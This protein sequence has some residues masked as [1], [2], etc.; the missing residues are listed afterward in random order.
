MTAYRKNQ[1]AA[2]MSINLDNY[3]LLYEHEEKFA[4]FGIELPKYS[5]IS[6]L[7]KLKDSLIK[8][9][10]VKNELTDILE[11]ICIND[12]GNLHLSNFQKIKCSPDFKRML[13]DVYDIITKLNADI[14]K[15]RIKVARLCNETF[16][17][18]KGNLKK[19]N[20]SLVELSI[21][22]RFD[23]PEYNSISKT[24]NVVL[25]HI[26]DKDNKDRRNYLSHGEKNILALLLF[27]YSCKEDIVIIDDPASSTDE[28]KRKVILNIIEK[29]QKNETY[30]ILSHDQVF[31]KYAVLSKYD[32]RHPNN[33]I[34][35][36][37]CMENINSKCTIKN[38]RKDSFDKLEDQI[39]KHIKKEENMPYYRLIINMRLLA[40]IK[41]RYNQKIYGYLSAILHEETRDGIYSALEKSEIFGEA[42][43]EEK[44]SEILKL[45]SEKC[46][47]ISLTPVP[48]DFKDGLNF[49][50]LTDFE[51]AIWI[52]EQKRKERGKKRKSEFEKELDDIVHLN[53]S[54][55]ISLDPYKY[56]TFSPHI[57]NE[58]KKYEG[59]E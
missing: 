9:N 16:K 29:T 27:I 20:D 4:Q 7:D 5:K 59:G 26:E 54:Y 31:I 47:K 51:K 12:Y 34:G 57:N 30:I 2:I 36:I 8:L 41:C 48:E 49:S 21:P 17:L 40:E 38:I 13:P 22:Y 37:G 42:S 14:I 53:N 23:F 58:I 28:N 19:L 56:N 15:I 55:C 24:A 18:I 44:E 11:T 43:V 10:Q 45:I 33:Q 52:R 50:D 25:T 35:L 46:F 32:S 39:I 3:K 6:E 1:V